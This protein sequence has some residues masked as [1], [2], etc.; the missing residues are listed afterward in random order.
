V[1]SN[2]GFCPN[3]GFTAG[4]QTQFPIRQ[5]PTRWYEA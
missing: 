3:Q 2:N 1:N 4:W 5:P